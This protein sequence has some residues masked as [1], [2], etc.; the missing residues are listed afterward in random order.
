MSRAVLTTK[1][2]PL[3]FKKTKKKKKKSGRSKTGE[4]LPP[5]QISMDFFQRGGFCGGT[6]SPGAAGITWSRIVTVE[7]L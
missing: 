4:L 1:C 3:R 5:L 2:Q 7:G 6:I